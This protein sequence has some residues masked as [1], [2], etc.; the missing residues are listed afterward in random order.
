MECS[1][2]RIA[3]CGFDGNGES[4][5]MGCSDMIHNAAYTTNSVILIAI[6]N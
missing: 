1:A 5:M 6:W 4:V 3:Y 2:I